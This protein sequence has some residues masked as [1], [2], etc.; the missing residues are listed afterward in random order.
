MLQLDIVI[1]VE[2]LNND[3]DCA[4]ATSADKVEDTVRKDKDNYKSVTWTSEDR[5]SIN[6][7]FGVLSETNTEAL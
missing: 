1:A 4:R 2:L 7:R 5:I 6:N 3:D